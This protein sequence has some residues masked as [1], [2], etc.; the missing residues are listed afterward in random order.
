MLVR[1]HGKTALYGVH[2]AVMS[3]VDLDDPSAVLRYARRVC[4]NTVAEIRH[5]Q[6]ET[7]T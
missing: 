1:S 3:D 4:E 6:E 5:R 2:E 7:A